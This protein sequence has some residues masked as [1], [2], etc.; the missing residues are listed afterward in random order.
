MRLDRPRA[1]RWAIASSNTATASSMESALAQRILGVGQTFS[2]VREA[3]SATSAIGTKRKRRHDPDRFPL[4][5]RSL[6]S[7]LVP[8]RDWTFI[9]ARAI[10]SKYGTLLNWPVSF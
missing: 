10:A 6:I 7:R 4:A 1:Q 5:T 9:T 8:S 2:N 3:L